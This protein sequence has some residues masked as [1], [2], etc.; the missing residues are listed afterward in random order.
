MANEIN[1]NIEFTKKLIDEDEKEL[2]IKEGIRGLSKLLT[3]SNDLRSVCK[4]SITFICEYSNSSV[5]A[6]YILNENDEDEL[7]MY[8]S[9]AYVQRD[10]LSNKFKLGEG[11]VG[12]VGLQKTPIH[13]RNI[14][15]DEFDVE[16]G[17]TKQPPINIYTFPLL[18][19]DELYG[20]AEVASTEI[21]KEH[22]KRLFDLSS[23]IIATALFTSFQNR[24]VKNLLK[25][26]KKSN[27]ELQENQAKLEEANAQM[28]EQQAQLEE[29]NAQMQE[30]QAQLE[31]ANAQ[32][33]EQQVQLQQSEQE[34]KK[35]NQ[36]LQATQIDI[37]KKAKALEESN[38]YKS[39]FLANMSHELRTPLNS[40][41][42]L[43]SMMEQ[44]KKNN[45]EQDD[46]K[47]ASIINKSGQ[48]LLRLI[49]DVLDLSKVEAGK[50]ELIIDK[51]HST[52]F[53]SSIKDLFETSA[54]SK[55][56]EFIVEDNYNDYIYNDEDKLSQVV[57]NFLSNSLKF[58][59]KGFI[60]LSLNKENNN[61]R[62]DVEDSGIGIPKE[63]QEIIFQAFSQVDGSTSRQYGGT[64]LGLSITKEFIKLM[65]GEVKVDSKE[66]I[67]SVF[68]VIIPN[69][70]NK[71]NITNTIKHNN[72]FTNNQTQEKYQIIDDRDNL[73]NESIPF[74]IIE[75]NITFAQTLKDLINNKNELCLIANNGKDGLKLAQEYYN[76]QGILLDLGLPDIDGVEVLKELKSNINTK[77]I[78][79]YIISGQD[80][81]DSS[82]IEDA[83]GFKQKPLNNDDFN[84]LIKDIKEFNN[85]D[86]KNL[87]IVEDDK[88]QREAMIEFVSNDSINIKGIDN[89]EEAIEEIN[90]N[91]YDAVVVDLT[92]KGKS[93]LDI[94]EYIKQENLSIPIIIY[95]GKDITYEE[96]QKINKF[97]DSII[98]KSVNSQNRLLDEVNLFLHKVKSNKKDS[99][100]NNT[101]NNTSNSID[102]EDKKILV[103][104]DDMRN[105]FV[106]VEIL[107]D[108]NAT[109]LT[110][111]NGQEAL[112]VLEDNKDTDIILMDV[113]M[114]VM[115]GYEAIEKIRED[116]SIKDIPIIAI[117][118][119]AMNKDKEKALAV[120]A[121]DYLTKP[122][123]LDSF[124][125]V[126]NSWIK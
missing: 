37:D 14:K 9:Y 109:I 4:N 60:K 5:G 75:D 23:D 96:E 107:E 48:E 98:V 6:F 21:F 108:K 113:M 112:D 20:V 15:K 45:L 110:A 70:A 88:I 105:T 84:S 68:S 81:T 94:C 54:Q 80:N 93:G 13:L 40:I 100:K 90:K 51:F 7:T 111:Q 95:T 124:V 39:E 42:L 91:Q 67:G 1:K 120:G 17:T 66:N 103:V 24:K 63:K 114:P 117:T 30:Q 77:R 41:I 82:K 65:K 115:D 36:E 10:S 56:L 78:P 87:L 22:T 76:I 11:I 122:L 58:T 3:Q 57:R 52:D 74:L 72:N 32:M 86:I 79:V 85:K 18:Y 35:Q 83:I 116:E 73:T 53:T 28:Q 31:E 59:E 29:A 69:I 89:V 106:L 102:F 101:I 8:S 61:V 125:G 16:T 34:L 46:I 19:K 126:V 33:E 104:D 97:T 43:S 55:E 44:N 99:A 62:I 27:I 123:N 64:G 47:K 12:Q 118:A 2:F 71:I 25:D 50:M 119:K 38:K 92:L 26:T 49:N 121:N